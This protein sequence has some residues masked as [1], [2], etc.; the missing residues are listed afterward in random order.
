MSSLPQFRINAPTVIHE[1]FDD[2]V[3]IIDFDTGSY[4]SLDGVG[5][6][7]WGIIGSGAALE[8][9]IR[10]LASRYGVTREAIENP[11]AQL[12]AELQR[13]NLIVADE[14]TTRTST[15]GPAMQLDLA[16]GVETPSFEA[17]TLHKYTDMQELLLLDPI[18][19]VD[20]AGWP[21]PRP[22]PP[23]TAG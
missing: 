14:A 7:V 19:D 3:V 8:E 10:I 13:E 2:E 22:D 11:V 17:L 1:T 12:V 21:N 20:E 4:Y 9:I 5:V 6:A 18:H 15:S 23:E 16:P